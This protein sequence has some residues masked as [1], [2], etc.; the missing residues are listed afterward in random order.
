ML[1]SVLK[2][3]ITVKEY[4]LAI[5]KTAEM[6]N[7]QES[8]M[9][10]I[11]SGKKE[12]E[13]R[14]VQMKNNNIKNSIFVIVATILAVS[15]LTISF[16][17]DK[18]TESNTE[19]IEMIGEIFNEIENQEEI[20]PEVEFIVP[21]EYTNVTSRFG[22]RIHPITKEEK[23]HTGVDLAAK[24]GTKVKAAASGVVQ[25]ATFD[26]EKGNYVEIKHVD[27]S[28]SSYHHGSKILVEAGDTVE[29]GDEI[30]VVGQTG[31]ATGTHLHFEVRNADNEYMNVNVLID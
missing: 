16:A 28:V 26:T 23:T 22:T 5:L 29:A 19:N 1:H 21:I 20:I 25:V 24:E 13:R 18:V 27:G 31:N 3:N 2:S 4:C 10:S 12:I 8:K 14:I 11:C 7:L 17:S 9:P 15:V 30:M 6:C